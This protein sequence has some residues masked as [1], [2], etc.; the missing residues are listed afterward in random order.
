MRR[1]FFCVGNF[2]VF[3]GLL[4]LVGCD[5]AKEYE[6]LRVE[7]TKL[8]SEMRRLREKKNDLRN[9]ERNLTRLVSNFEGLQRKESMVRIE[10]SDITKY[11]RDLTAAFDY[12]SSLC[13]L[14]EVATRKSLIGGNLGLVRLAEGRVLTKTVV[15]ELTDEEVTLKHSEGQ[16]SVALADLPESLRKKLLHEP[17]IL[18]ETEIVN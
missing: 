6:E 15:L 18:L 2:W 14:W 7:N 5:S 8:I 11:Q 9:E 3:C 10:L 17:T 12:T 13:D 4:L 16:E 1:F